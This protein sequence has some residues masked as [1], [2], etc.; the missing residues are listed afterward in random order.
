MSELWYFPEKKPIA[1]FMFFPLSRPFYSFLTMKCIEHL[2]ELDN[3]NGIRVQKDFFM[4]HDTWFS[5][6]DLLF[7]AWSRD[8]VKS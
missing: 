8:F 3:S 1:F 5:R 7:L 2:I 4:I 6:Y